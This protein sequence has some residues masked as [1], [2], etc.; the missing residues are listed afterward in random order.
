MK[1]LHILFA[2]LFGVF[3][4][5]SQDIKYPEI[6]ISNGIIKA[7]LYLPDAENGYYKGT[8]FDWSGVISN[9]EFNEHTYFGQW[10]DADNA[11][12]F[13][14]IMGPVEAYAP[15]NYND[16]PV[17]E[18]FVKIGVGV[19]KKTADENYS[20]FKNY[21]I[22]NPGKRSLKTNAN[23]VEF[24]HVVN[25]KTVSYVYTKT[26]RL[27]ENQS[28]MQVSHVLKNTG[29][30][31]IKTFG[32]NHNFLVIDNQ[33]IGKDFEMIFPVEVSGIGRGLGDIFEI[34]DKRL[35]F[36]RDIIG[37]ESIAI[38]H[39][40]GLN[41]NVDNFDISIHNSKTGAGVKITGDQPLSRF[42]LW[43]TSKTICPETYIDIKVAPG[44]TFSWSYFY[45]FYDSKTE[46]N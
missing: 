4:G 22:I 2:I 10:F 35:I 11:P 34:E 16:V 25:T 18:G 6:E 28:I 45:E 17:G 30:H 29:K 44:E 27:V 12:P 5:N 39:L 46:R 42:R 32:F 24:G 15:L 26:I 1:G 9:L 8:R 33:T 23:T 38:K 37:D 36:E 31:Q 43:G 40:E 19:L 41:N 14:T 13:A 21:E 7:N 3:Q 20:D